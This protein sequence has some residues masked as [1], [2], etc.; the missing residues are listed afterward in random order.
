MCDTIVLRD[1]RDCLGPGPK[2]RATFFYNV[3]IICRVFF[4]FKI[5]K[6][7][8]IPVGKAYSFSPGG[9]PSP[10][11]RSVPG[12]GTVPGLQRDVWT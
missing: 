10:S 12:T 3:L 2:V 7:Y 1:S 4:F 8:Q 9:V 11:F 5:L 6:T